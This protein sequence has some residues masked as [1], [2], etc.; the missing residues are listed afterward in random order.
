M[1]VTPEIA[2]TKICHANQ[3]K[4]CHAGHCMAWR[5][6]SAPLGTQGAPQSVQDPKASGEGVGFCGL[7]GNPC[8][9]KDS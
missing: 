8:D 5:W 1:L 7:A 9:V 2:V 4:H 6:L 3:D